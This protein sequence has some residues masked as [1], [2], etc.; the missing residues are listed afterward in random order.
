[1]GTPSTPNLHTTDPSD[2]LQNTFGTNIIKDIYDN[3]P[4]SPPVS[5]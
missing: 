4:Q 5:P 3:N 2:P 1:M